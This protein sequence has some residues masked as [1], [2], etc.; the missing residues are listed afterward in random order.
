MSVE[1][2]CKPRKEFEF[3]DEDY[4]ALGVSLATAAVVLF[5]KQGTGTCLHPGIE[6]YS[7]GY[8][9]NT[10]NMS[11]FRKYNDKIILQNKQ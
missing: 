7:I 2:K 3:L 5:T 1:A 8:V 11:T 6:H 10:W 9:S 4:P